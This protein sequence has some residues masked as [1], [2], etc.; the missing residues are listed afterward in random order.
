MEINTLAKVESISPNFKAS[1]TKAQEAPT[2]SSI[3]MSSYRSPMQNVDASAVQSGK[4]RVDWLILSCLVLMFIFLQ[5]DR[6][7]LGNALTDNFAAGIRITQK[8]INI[9]QTLFTLGIVLFEIPGNIVIKRFGANRWLPCLMFA[10]GLVTL[11]QMFITSRSSFYATRFLLATFEAGFI[12][13]AAFYL[14]QFYTRGEMALRYALLWSANSIAGALAGVLALGL[15]SLDGRGGL[16]GW[17]WLWLIEGVL[18]CAIAIFALFHLPA[19]PQR[20]CRNP[21]LG[22]KFAILSEAQS[23][24]LTARVIADDP[25]KLSQKSRSVHLRDFDFF[26]DWK[27]YGHCFMGFLT[28]VMF[29]PINTYAPSIIKSLGFLGYTANGLN[30][31]GSILCLI[32][33]LSLAWNSDRTRERGLHIIV[34]F[35]ISAIGLLWLALPPS[36]VSRGVLYAGVIVTQGGMGSVQGIN[37]AWLSSKIEERHR[38]LALGAYVMSIQLA[39]FVGSNLFRAVDAPRYRRGLLICAGCVLGGVVIAALWKALYF[40]TEKRESATKDSTEEQDHEKVRT[41]V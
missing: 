36:T 25:T 12:P 11:C 38:P 18:T 10:W 9:G 35:C 39:G 26:L 1:E 6:T 33:S 40:V 41:E 7:S 16:E 15:L 32:I 28:S 8:E 19:S 14:G 30:S 17:Q 23:E 22:K 4:L 3:S 37:A 31:V 21:I 34:G 20:A 2:Q 29:Q 5:F 27:I 13:G 24:A